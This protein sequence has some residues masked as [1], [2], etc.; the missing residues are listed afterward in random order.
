MQLNN[1]DIQE[2]KDI[3]RREFSEELSDAEAERRARQLLTFY[4]A[5][6]QILLRDRTRAFCES[7]T[8]DSTSN[9]GI[10]DDVSPQ[11]DSTSHTVRMNQS[12][13]ARPPQ[14]DSPPPLSP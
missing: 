11:S 3:Y 7:P 5:I 14:T 1:D 12:A 10:L 13:K 8:I 6:F 2:F 4:E 9:D